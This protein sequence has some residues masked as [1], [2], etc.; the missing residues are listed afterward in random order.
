[1]TLKKILAASLAA[2]LA[3]SM[4][5]CGAK[6]PAEETTTAEDTTAAI[7]MEAESTE[8]VDALAEESTEAAAATEAATEAPA[9]EATTAEQKAPETEAP[10]EAETEAEKKVPQT[11]EEIV[12]FYKKAATE[13][14][15][16]KITANTK[17]ELVDLQADGALSAFVKIFKPAVANALSKNSTP[18]DHVTGGYK[19]LTADDVASATAS[20]D[21]KYTT[22]TINLKDQ[23]DGFNGESKSGHVGH[24]VTV[25][26]SVQNAINEIDGLSAEQG[27]G[28]VQLK[29]NNAKIDVKVD[30]ETGKIVSGK[31]FYKV[32]ILIDNVKMKMGILSVTPKGMTGTVTNTVTL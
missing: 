18:T 14:D 32:D 26:G 11:K 20:D 23:T 17:M 25:L 16:N 12:E 15:K 9:D 21:G 29:Y 28:T 1:M 27:D 10:T 6:E 8:A 5:A 30:N 22:I 2:I 7:V 4:A 31:W 24:G 19:N 3:L 13:T